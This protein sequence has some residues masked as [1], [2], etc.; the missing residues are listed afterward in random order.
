MDAIERKA[1]QECATLENNVRQQLSQIVSYNTVD[2][3]PSQDNPD[4]E[5]KQPAEGGEGVA[6]NGGQNNQYV[7]MPLKDWAITAMRKEATNR[8]MAFEQM[9][10]KL[11]TMKESILEDIKEQQDA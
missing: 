2:V 9:I 6:R 3:D 7:K 5:G 4:T 11:D 1:K 10:L 8:N